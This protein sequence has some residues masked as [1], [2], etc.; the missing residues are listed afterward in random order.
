MHRNI[1]CSCNYA[2]KIRKNWVTMWNLKNNEA[3]YV[4]DNESVDCKGFFLES[5]TIY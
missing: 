1:T 2:N 4:H 3:Y 5:L